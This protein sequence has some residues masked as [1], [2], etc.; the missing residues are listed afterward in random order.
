VIAR[1]RPRKYDPLRDHL[2]KAGAEPVVMTFAEIEALVGPLPRSAREH[3][4]WWQNESIRSGH[5]HAGAWLDA[6]RT[7]VAFDRT[8]G[9]VRFSGTG[10]Q[11][12]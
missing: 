6:G 5:V 8:S 12:E 4:P 9:W 10:R 11:P 2:L 3:D 1:S 7:V